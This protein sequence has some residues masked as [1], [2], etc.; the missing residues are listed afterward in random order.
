MTDIMM[1]IDGRRAHFRPLTDAGR[2]WL[3]ENFFL[4]DSE[5]DP[6]FT[7]WHDGVMKPDWGPFDEEMIAGAIDDGIVVRVL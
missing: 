7:L 3:D 1:R 5:A 4:V 2:E 6:D